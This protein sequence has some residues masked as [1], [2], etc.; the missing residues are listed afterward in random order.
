MRTKS[1]HVHGKRAE[2]ER[3]GQSVHLLALVPLILNS[4]KVKV[5]R[6][7]PP[8]LLVIYIAL[9]ANKVVSS[10]GC[11]AKSLNALPAPLPED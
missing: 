10:P 2:T 11:R 8:P 1:K 3:A 9:L 5:R 7:R 4:F 6:R